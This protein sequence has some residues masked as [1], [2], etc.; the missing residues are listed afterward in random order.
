V[1]VGEDQ[2]NYQYIFSGRKIVKK[3][4]LAAILSDRFELNKKDS[5]AA[6]DAVFDEIARSLSKGEAV[7][8]TGF[9]TFKKRVVPARKARMGRNPFTGE[10]VKIAAKKASSKPTFTATK[11]LKEVVTGVTKLPAAPKPTAKPV[12]KPAA[13][14]VAKKAPAK[15]APVKKA[16]AKKAPAKKVVA[17]KAPAKKVVAKKAPAKKV[18]AKKAPARRK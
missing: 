13:K 8:L 10:A 2:H 17:K 16:V 11:A 4:D 15:K 14:P 6:V 7:A 9:G 18:V 12:A 5:I 1:L 3:T